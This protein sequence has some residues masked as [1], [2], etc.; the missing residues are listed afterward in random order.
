MRRR[1]NYGGSSWDRSRAE[2]YCGA[3]PYTNNQNQS[4]VSIQYEVCGC[5]EEEDS[6]RATIKYIVGRGRGR[7][8]GKQRVSTW[9]TIVE[10]FAET[11][12]PF[13][14]MGALMQGIKAYCSLV[15]SSILCVCVSV[16]AL[17]FHYPPCFLILSGTGRRRYNLY[18]CLMR[19]P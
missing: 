4:G 15:L 16:V 2:A 7:I 11:I 17:G 5:A 9:R 8:S 6:S 14:K 1:N 13:L 18:D 12:T 10:R 19:L 3:V